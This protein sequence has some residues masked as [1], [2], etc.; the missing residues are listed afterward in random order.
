ML[1]VLAVGK[2]KSRPLSELVE[3]YAARLKRYGGVDIVEIKDS[4]PEG[5]GEKILERLKNFRG[6]VWA[7]SEE[8]K[9]MS[10]REFSAALEKN[11]AFGDTAFIIGG[12]Y[13]LSDRVRKRSDFIFSMSP[14]TFTHEYA[15]AVLMEQLYR[16]KCISANTPYHH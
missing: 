4:S 12:S 8:G 1:K 10:S 6:K 13:G 15:R 14:M 3:D 7:C 9:A 2:M 11:L 5:E 16:A